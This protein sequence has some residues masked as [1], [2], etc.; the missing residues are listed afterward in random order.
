MRQTILSLVLGMGLAVGTFGAAHAQACQVDASKESGGSVEQLPA[1]QCGPGLAENDTIHQPAP[2][3]QPVAQA[4][5][6]VPQTQLVGQTGQ[7][8]AFAANL[9]AVRNFWNY[10][11]DNWSILGFSSAAQARAVL[12]GQWFQ[13]AAQMAGLMFNSSGQM[14]R[15]SCRVTTHEGAD[16]AQGSEQLPPGQCQ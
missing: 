1:G 8:S 2:S 15:D 10:T 9:Q 3:A 6:P 5:Q 16:S 12:G 11:Q 7:L 13:Q 4:A 14:V